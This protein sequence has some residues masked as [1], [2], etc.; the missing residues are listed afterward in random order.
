MDGAG[1]RRPDDPFPRPFAASP[2]GATASIPLPAG[3]RVGPYTGRPAPSECFRTRQTERGVRT[4][5][6]RG[7]RE[8]SLT[9]GVHAKSGPGPPV[10]R[11]RGASAGTHRSIA[12][13][14][15][16]P[17]CP[18]EPPVRERPAAK[19]KT[20]GL[21]C[22]SRDRLSGLGE[23]PHGVRRLAQAGGY[24]TE[25]AT[26]GQ[27][28]YSSGGRGAAEHDAVHARGLTREPARAEGAARPVKGRR[29]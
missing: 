18:N 26:R 19:G 28:R 13:P 15:G 16:N 24:S 23:R 17:M 20:K 1:A 4:W 25:A 6:N 5:W 9:V 8:R 11:R 2:H 7:A 22:R 21:A 29:T 12:R 27:G 14:T 3:S 10:A